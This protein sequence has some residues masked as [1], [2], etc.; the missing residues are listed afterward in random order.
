MLIDDQRVRNATPGTFDKS[1]ENIFRSICQNVSSS[2]IGVGQFN[3]LTSTA[4]PIRESLKSAL[5]N[6]VYTD[7]EPV[8]IGNMNY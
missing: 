8:P 1:C 2:H 4:I 7:T 5:A 3:P 6:T